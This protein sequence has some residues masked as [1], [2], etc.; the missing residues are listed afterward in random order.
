[1]KLKESEK[2]GLK[3]NIQ[4]TNMASGP[5]TSWQIDEEKMETFF[6]LGSRITVTVTTAMKLEDTC[7][8]E[9]SYDKPRQCIKKQRHHFTDKGPYSQ[10][11]GFS[12]SQVW[13]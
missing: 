3:C 11:C 5:I 4:K 2:A 1:M 9:K 7:S 6:F 13:M 12:S 10:S 8:L